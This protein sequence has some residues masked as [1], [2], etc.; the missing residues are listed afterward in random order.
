MEVIGS[1]TLFTGPAQPAD[2]SLHVGSMWQNSLTGAM[3]LC[4]QIAPQVEFTQVGYYARSLDLTDN[5]YIPIVTILIADLQMIS[6]GIEYMIHCANITDVQ[7]LG[8]RMI[9]SAVRKGAAFDTQIKFP[10]SEQTLAKSVG[11]L[12]DLWRMTPLVDRI[13]IEVKAN[14]SLAGITHFHLHHKLMLRGTTAENP[15]I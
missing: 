13:I 14:T 7:C 15:I 5:V 9:F 2:G 6:G 8:G 11:T 12:A 1:G 4:T 3:Y 10:D